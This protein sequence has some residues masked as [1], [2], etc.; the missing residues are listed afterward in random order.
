MSPVIAT[1]ACPKTSDTTLSGTP[2]DNITE[3]AECRSVCSP[4]EEGS[5]ARLAAAFKAR[6]ALRGSEGSPSSVVNTYG[7]GCH[8]EPAPQPLDPLIGAHV[9]QQPLRSRGER[10]HSARPRRLRFG[11]NELAGDAGERAAYPEQ[12]LVKVNVGPMQGER[13][14]AA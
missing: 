5:P 13:L 7:V 10:D 1:L 3:A 9:A 4:T 11:H 6:S 8:I 12:P 2:A 14:A